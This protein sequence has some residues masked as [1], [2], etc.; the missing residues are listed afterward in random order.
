GV[1]GLGGDGALVVVDQIVLHRAGPVRAGQRRV[2]AQARGHVALG[3]R[4]GDVLGH[5][6]VPVVEEARGGGGSADG[7]GH[8]VQPAG[9][10]VGVGDVGVRA[11]RDLARGIVAEA[12]VFV[13]GRAGEILGVAGQAVDVVVEGDGDRGGLV[14]A[15]GDDVLALFV[16]GVVGQDVGRGG[17]A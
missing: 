2:A 4:A 14:G 8:G 17:Q 9:G 13:V 15:L 3:E 11:G 12:L 7:V 6:Q 1:V 16:E 10:D 5:Q